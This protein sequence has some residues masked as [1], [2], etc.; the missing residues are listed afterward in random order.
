L[1]DIEASLAHPADLSLAGGIDHAEAVAFWISEDD[2]VRIC[3]PF[4]PMDLGRAQ[5]DQALDLSSLILR[6]EIEVKARRDLQ[7]R[8]HLIE[9]EMR[10][11]PVSRA[12]ESEVVA[13]SV[14]AANVAEGRL[15]ELRLT[16]QIVD[17]QNDRADTQHC[18]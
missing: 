9:R 7:R 11:V 8:A 14:V 6:V 15:P 1:T 3:G 16:P 4:V 5:C 12:E 2:K 10:A 17:P 13:L 18:R